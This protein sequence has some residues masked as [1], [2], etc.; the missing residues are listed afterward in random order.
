MFTYIYGKNH[1]FRIIRVNRYGPL[2]GDIDF[3]EVTPRSKMNVD[4]TMTINAFGVV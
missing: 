2:L 3:V 4:I 1:I